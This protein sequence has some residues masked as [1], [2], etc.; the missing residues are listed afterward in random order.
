MSTMQFFR[1]PEDLYYTN[2]NRIS[3]IYDVRSYSELCIY[4]VICQYYY[5]KIIIFY[6]SKK[7]TL[8]IFILLFLHMFRYISMHVVTI[9]LFHH[10]QVHSQ[11]TLEHIA[12]VLMAHAP[13]GLSTGVCH[14]IELFKVLNL[15]SG[16]NFFYHC[17]RVFYKFLSYKLV[18]FSSAMFLSVLLT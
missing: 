1:Y 16:P 13:Q 7:F 4:H 17:L 2:V 9:Q 15:E 3:P 5:S 6:I 10:H 18:L 14:S 12:L 8:T 11:R